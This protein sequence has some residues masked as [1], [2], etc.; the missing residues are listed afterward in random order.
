LPSTNASAALCNVPSTTT[1]NSFTSWSAMEE[2]PPE[3]DDED[4][5]ALEP[6][7]SK[8]KSGALCDQSTDRLLCHFCSRSYRC[9]CFSFTSFDDGDDGEKR[10]S[11]PSSTKAATVVV[12]V[13]VAPRGAVP[14][15]TPLMLLKSE[16]RRSN[17][18]NHD[19]ERIILSLFALSYFMG[20]L[21]GEKITKKGTRGFVC[22]SSSR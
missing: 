17:A 22:Y 18:Q 7:S 8:F 4:E 12:A 5:D 13:V 10:R 3:D 20:K 19:R 15:T 1:S 9:G 11:S 14:T 16:E 21:G 6:S 2:D